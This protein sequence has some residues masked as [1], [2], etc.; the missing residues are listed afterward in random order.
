M[1]N[2]LSGYRR[3]L[4]IGVVTIIIGI[5]VTTNLSD[6]ISSLGIILIAVGVLLFVIGIG[7]KKSR[8]SKKKQKL[9]TAMSKKYGRKYRK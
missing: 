5:L 1:S 6:Q 8:S 4:Y 9:S 7:Q 3:Y 2:N